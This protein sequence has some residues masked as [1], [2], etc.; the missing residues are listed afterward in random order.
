M[1]KLELFFQYLIPAFIFFTVAY[2]F[3]RKTPINH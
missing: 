1:E 2:G 3:A